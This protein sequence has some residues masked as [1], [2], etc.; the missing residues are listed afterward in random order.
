MCCVCLCLHYYSVDVPY[1]NGKKIYVNSTFH[2]RK[3]FYCDFLNHEKHKKLTNYD[4]LVLNLINFEK[5]RYKSELELQIEDFFALQLIYRKNKLLFDL[6][7][8]K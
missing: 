7:Y 4:F 2:L 1:H 5:L 6:F 8:K 3:R